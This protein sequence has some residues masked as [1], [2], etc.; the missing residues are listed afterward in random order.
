[1]SGAGARAIVVGAGIV[2]AACACEL[3][4]AGFQVCIV[5]SQAMGGGATAAGMGHVVVMDDSEPQFELTRYSQ[6]LWMELLPELPP[7]CEVLRCGTLWV[8]ADEDDLA[9]VRRKHAFAQARGV[10]TEIL[11][12]RALY[13]AEPHLRR[14]LRG[15][16]R[17]PDDSVVFP[18]PVAAFLI[19][20]ARQHG[21]ELRCGIPARA[22]S[23]KRVELADGTVLESDLVVNATGCLATAFC[24]ELGLRARKGHLIITERY[25][26]LV[27]HQM[28]E[29]GYLKSAAGTAAESVAFNVQPRPTGQLLIGSS[30]QFGDLTTDVRFELLAQMVRRALEYLPGLAH[31]LALRVWTG[32]RAATSDKLPFI[33]PHPETGVHLALGHEGLGITTSLGTA[34]LLVDRIL[35]RPS[36]IPA[37]PYGPEPRRFQAE[38]RHV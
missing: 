6:R 1:M 24:P 15:G 10:R 30:R 32:F 38:D 12:E 28:I 34:R 17:A 9:E 18:P 7:A 4:R 37:E 13:E 23:A 25:P 3:A 11:D 22:L 2:G 31:I 20:R 5:E 21:A 16:L 29:L 14:G 35:N 8:A 27:R 26:D 36:A 33:G 19:S